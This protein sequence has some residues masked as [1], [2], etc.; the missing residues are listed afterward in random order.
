MGN[1]GRSTG[2]SDTS[3][4]ALSA[5]AVAVV[6]GRDLDMDG[7][8]FFVGPTLFDQVDT[9]MSVYRDEIFGPVLVIVRVTLLM[10]RSG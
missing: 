9:E 2:S 6:D 5:G 7:D 1:S 10:T 8:G 4:R 3:A